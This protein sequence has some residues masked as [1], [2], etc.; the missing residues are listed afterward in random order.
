M[1]LRTFSPS[2]VCGGKSSGG[3]AQNVQEEK[4]FRVR[5]VSSRFVAIIALVAGSWEDLGFR[6]SILNTLHH[7]PRTDITRYTEEGTTE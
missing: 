6:P 2:L 7:A 1:C 4:C 3:S 5:R